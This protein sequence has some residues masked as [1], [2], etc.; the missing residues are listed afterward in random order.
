[1][2]KQIRPLLFFFDPEFAHDTVRIIG[3]LFSVLPASSI[4]TRPFAYEHPSLRIK[5][6]G[7]EFPSPVGLA[8]GFDKS[9][10][11]LSLM[12]S[13]GF[14]F[15]EVGS[16]TAKA[17][18]GNPRQRLFRLPVDSA[19]INRMGLNNEGADRVAERV[20]RFKRKIPIGVNLAKTN[21]PSISGSDAVR[22][23]LYSYETMSPYCDYIVLNISCPN[24]AD[25]KTFEEGDAL[26]ELLS[27]I[28][29]SKKNR[30]SA[31]P[32]FLK[33]SAD[34]SFQQLDDII[35][36]ASNFALDGYVLSNTTRERRGL[37][38]QREIIDRIGE[39]GLSGLP[40]KTKS[41]EM[42]RHV[43]KNFGKPSIIGVGGIFTG[44][45][46]YEKIKAGASLVQIYSSIVYRGPFVTK[47]IC[48]EL[49]ELLT[50]DGF[51]SVQEA[52][53]CEIP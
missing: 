31:Q 7:V 15:L 29:V 25:G 50:R 22:D 14:G 28:T 38:T 41:T 4:F 11:L 51:T 35:H 39:G 52:R 47:K 40:L 20:R 43:Y 1:M 16:V 34:L 36:I 5:V 2:Y 46:A 53:G 49:A 30:Q 42:I 21:D 32:L 3:K 18:V 26:K 37:L 24:S 10:E 48:M 8:A 13:L 45:D 44:N 12:Q 9:A 17:A 6:E 27:A 33:L 23:Y 19:I